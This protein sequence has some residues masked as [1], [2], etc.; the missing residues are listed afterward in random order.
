MMKN[1]ALR[2]Q[3][4]LG[5]FKVPYI[6]RYLSSQLSDYDSHG[7]CFPHYPLPDILSRSSLPGLLLRSITGLETVEIGVSKVGTMILGSS[8]NK[9]IKHEELVPYQYCLLPLQTP[10]VLCLSK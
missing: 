3:A 4:Y 5:N 10:C 6:A 8:C 9:L 2:S 7:D 1:R